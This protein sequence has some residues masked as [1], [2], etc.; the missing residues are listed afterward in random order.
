[1]LREAINTESLEVNKRVDKV[2][3]DRMNDVADVQA[4]V[5][6]SIIFVPTLGL[7]GKSQGTVLGL[8]KSV[9]YPRIFWRSSTRRAFLSEQP[10]SKTGVSFILLGTWTRPYK[11]IIT[12]N[13]H[14]ANH[15]PNFSANS[16]A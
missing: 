9:P 11:E 10:V 16:N 15:L 13:F 4:K 3:I 14:H 5:F 12:V 2:N 6:T 8:I 7:G 1:M